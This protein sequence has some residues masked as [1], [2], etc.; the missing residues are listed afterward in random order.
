[1]YHFGNRGLRDRRQ[2]PFDQPL[3]MKTLE[4][5]Q[6]L[7]GQKKEMRNHREII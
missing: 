4:M 1:M 2:L 6:I 7:F 3:G 5:K